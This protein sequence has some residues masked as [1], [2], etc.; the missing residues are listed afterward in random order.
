MPRLLLKRG[1]ESAKRC[2]T[3][4]RALPDATA[5]AAAPRLY[6]ARDELR[7]RRD[8][9]G[10]CAV[11]GGGQVPDHPA[12]CRHQANVRRVAVDGRQHPPHR[13]VLGHL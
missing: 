9:G 7:S 5:G 10:S 13:A 3:P 11:T 2:L 4:P 12:G 8:G 1:C 6:D